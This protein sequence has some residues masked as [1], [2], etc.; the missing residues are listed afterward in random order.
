MI[1]GVTPE[2]MVDAV[3]GMKQQNLQIEA[4]YRVMKSVMNLQQEMAKKLF[5][6]MGIGQN[7][8]LIG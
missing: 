8:D 3:L 5:E 4:N 7:I 2:G 1:E 6:S